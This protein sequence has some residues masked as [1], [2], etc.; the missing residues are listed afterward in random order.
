MIIPIEK[1]SPELLHSIIEEFVTREGSDYGEIEYSLEEK[2]AQVK[3]QLE[4]GQA[5]VVFNPEDETCSIVR[6]GKG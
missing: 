3:L 6:N 2:V 5:C 1:L 4:R